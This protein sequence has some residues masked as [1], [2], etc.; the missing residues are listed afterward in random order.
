M[1]KK[2]KQKLINICPGTDLYEHLK[3]GDYYET[4][5]YL[6]ELFDNVDIFSHEFSV[7]D[8]LYEGLK[9]ND[10]ESL[11][12]IINTARELFII[13]VIMEVIKYH[14]EKEDEEYVSK[15]GISNSYFSIL[16]YLS[17]LEVLTDKEIDE[18][19][20]AMLANKSK[21]YSLEASLESTL[22]LPFESEDNGLKANWIEALIHGNEITYQFLMESLLYDSADKFMEKFNAL[23]FLR[24]TYLSVMNP[25]LIELDVAAKRIRDIGLGE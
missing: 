25:H 20:N 15:K 2:L 3:S 9:A 5:D 6:V 7:F 11:K 18:F 8:S 14:L 10:S 4:L 12:A 22:S 17:R 23:A 21:K 13:E 16:C 19:I 24:K 1:D